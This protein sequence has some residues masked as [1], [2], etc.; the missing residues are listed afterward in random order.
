MRLPIRYK[1]LAVTGFLLMAAVGAYTWLASFIFFEQKTALLFDINHSVA[2]N[3]ASQLRSQLELASDRL[4]FFASARITNPA[5]PFPLATLRDSSIEQVAI[6][7]LSQGEWIVVPSGPDIAN[8]AL[9]PEAVRPYLN[10]ALQTGSV[11]W[12]E[13]APK[14]KSLFYLGTRVDASHY[15]LA[16]LD[17]APLFQV[18]HT[19][20]IF[21]SLLMQ[22]NGK[23]L[24]HVES[25]KEISPQESFRHPLA[26]TAASHVGLSGVQRFS[27]DAQSFFGAYAPV[28][29]GDLVLVSQASQ[30]EVTSALA[31]LIR[32]SLLFGLIV[33][34]L[35]LIASILLSRSL[36]R[37]LQR[38]ASGVSALGKGQFDAQILVR[39]GDEVETLADSFN[40]MACALK[41]SR[42]ALEK[43]NQELEE[44]VQLRT[45][46]LRETNAQI[47][48]VQEKLLQSTQLAAAGEIAGQTAHELLNPL[49]AIFSR[50]ERSRLA[51][52]NRSASV[53]AQWKE[54]LS[55]WKTDFQEGGIQQWIQS[56]QAPSK[57]LPQRT[58]AEEDLQNLEALSGFWQEQS[59]LI[60]SDLDFVQEQSQRI[61]RIVDKMREL[62]R[63]SD[64]S[65]VSCRSAIEEAIAT[66]SDFLEQRGVAIRLEWTALQ[67]EAVLNKDELVQIL[68]NLLRNA[69]QAVRDSQSQTSG[70]IQVR[71]YNQENSL[72]VDIEDNGVGIAAENRNRLFE[73]GFTT[74]APQEGTGLGLAI[75][76]RYARAFGGEVELVFSAPNQGTCFRVTIPLRHAPAEAI[77]A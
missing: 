46:Q 5:A 15:I 66:L 27:L 62:V 64:K 56:L 1:I 28:G 12:S 4:R 18:L 22:A 69:Y 13:S 67:D 52:H 23:V 58:L 20:G 10:K 77:P 40:E 37:N 43:T 41:A 30:S 17:A 29:F 74:K 38:L 53:N 8:L 45:A 72:W 57:V 50:L 49:T 73:Q 11:F 19:S 25:Q 59:A 21:E 76:R 47:R 32:R 7:R 6:Y 9:P 33:L 48:S 63:A 24:L 42:Q 44:K 35:A 65:E 31:V 2:V 3:S 39:S 70:L 54:I 68:T 61:H 36:T 55:A 71:A 26:A 34:T 60:A 51:I 75:C 14:Q 16:S